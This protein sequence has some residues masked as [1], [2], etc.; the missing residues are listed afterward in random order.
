MATNPGTLTTDTLCGCCRK[1]VLCRFAL[2]GGVQMYGTVSGFVNTVRMTLPDRI[3]PVFDLLPDPVVNRID[4]AY[5]LISIVTSQPESG[6]LGTYSDQ[7]D[8]FHIGSGLQAAERPMTYADKLKFADAFNYL[9]T[10]C[11]SDN[12]VTYAPWVA[13]ANADTDY[14]TARVFDQW[15]IT[16]LCPYTTGYGRLVLPMFV[17]YTFE[18]NVQKEPDSAYTGYLV[19][20]EYGRMTYL[21]IDIENLGCHPFL[22]S[23]P[24]TV[25][26]ANPDISSCAEHV[27]VQKLGY[28]IHW[29]TCK[30][31]C[32]RPGI[33]FSG[34]LL[35]SE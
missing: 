27:G 24:L 34:V 25:E 15:G 3:K 18:M 29:Y 32:V 30:Y 8:V 19:G 21:E 35:L 5:P 22:I 26:S 13:N 20:Y 17:S 6:Y 10:G 14:Q 1:C 33:P 7:N 11:V 2:S 9:I 16:V 31:T 23:A 12:V 28:G 4:G